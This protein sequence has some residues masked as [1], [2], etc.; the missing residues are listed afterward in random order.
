MKYLKE[1]DVI[2][3]KMAYLMLQEIYLALEAQ[4]RTI[5]EDIKKTRE[6][7]EIARIDYRQALIE[8]GYN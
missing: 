4:K 7:L 1:L 2:E 5:D 6:S 8:H 3:A